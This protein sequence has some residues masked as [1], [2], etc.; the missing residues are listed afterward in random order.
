MAVD[1]YIEMFTTLYGWLMY[2]VVWDILAASGIVFLPF[3]GIILDNFFEAY[4][5]DSNGVSSDVA[6]RSAEIEVITAFVIA[7]LAASPSVNL[8]AENVQFAPK[9]TLAGEERDTLNA[10]DTTTTTYGSIAFT[11]LPNTVSVPPW[12]YLVMKVSKGITHAVREGVPSHLNYREYMQQ[13]SLI[14]IENQA[15]RLEANDFFRDCFVPAR[16]KYYRQLDTV[17]ATQF[18]AMQ[19]VLEEQGDEDTSYIGSRL[20]L[21]I[22]GYYD[23]LRARKLIKGFPFEASRDVEWDVANGET[24][25]EWGMPSCDTWWLGEAGGD[26]GLKQRLV[27]ELSDFDVLMSRFDFMSDEATR[28]DVLIKKLLAVSNDIGAWTPRDYDYAYDNQSEALDPGTRWLSQAGKDVSGII[29]L[30][31]LSVLFTLVLDIYLKASHMLQAF[32]LM[33]VYG[34]LPIAIVASRYRLGLLVAMAFVIFAINFWTAL[35]A[36]ANFFDQ[37]LIQAMLPEPGYKT[38]EG[39]LSN[40]Q[41]TMILNFLAGMNYLVFPLILTWM[42]SV[43]GFSVGQGLD[44]IV[45]RINWRLESGSSPKNALKTIASTKLK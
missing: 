17:D 14:E 24:P 42:F 39:I 23:S 4:A 20:F 13:I 11:D 29:S 32:M 35:W 5:K 37:A 26:L 33:L 40:V 7:M 12:W 19:T 36:W 6:L 43:A 25:P 27:T 10:L 2:N 16:S 9:P 34:L 30:S 8:D 21:S 28:H 22:P 3:L 18:T 1:S 45:S 31:A 44:S 38:L 15:L 41:K